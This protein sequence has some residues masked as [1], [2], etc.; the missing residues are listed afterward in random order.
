[1]ILPKS[2]S[3]FAVAEIKLRHKVQEFF[4]VL[5]AVNVWS[6]PSLKRYCNVKLRMRMRFSRDVKRVNAS[7]NFNG[8]RMRGNRDRGSER[9]IKEFSRTDL[10]NSEEQ[11]QEILGVINPQRSVD[12]FHHKCPLR[13]CCHVML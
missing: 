8:Y 13:F 9:G 1:M 6:M 11:F 10:A 3:S 2:L 5:K 12:T 4:R 7:S